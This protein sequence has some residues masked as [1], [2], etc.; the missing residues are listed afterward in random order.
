MLRY[1]VIFLVIALIAAVLGFGGIAAGAVDIAKILFFV[2][3]AIAV[4][5]FVVSLI[6]KK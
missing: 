1:A 6:N 5:T 3:I 2:F 4:I